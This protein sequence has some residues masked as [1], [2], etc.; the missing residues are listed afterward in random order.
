MILFSGHW[1]Q[2][3]ERRK[4]NEKADRLNVHGVA[5]LRMQ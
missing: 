4:E 5:A 3:L 2:I 1:G